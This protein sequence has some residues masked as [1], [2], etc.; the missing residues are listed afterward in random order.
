MLH[1]SR[2]A[3][4]RRSARH[5]N[6]ATGRGSFASDRRLQRRAA[7]PAAR[8]SVRRRFETGQ[9]RRGS[10]RRTLAEHAPPASARAARVRRDIVTR[11]PIVAID[12]RDAFAPQLRGW[13]RYAKELIA[14]LPEHDGLDFRFLSGGG[15]GPRLLYEQIGLPVRLRQM[16]RRP[17]PH[18]E[19]L[20]AARAAVHGR[21]DDPRPRLRGLPRGLQRPHRL[22]VPHVHAARRALGAARDLRLGLHG[23][24]RRAPLRRRRG[25]RADH[26]QRALAA[27]RRRADRRTARPLPARRRRPAPE[28]EP[29][30]PRRGVR[31]AAR[32]GA[33]APPRA[34]RRRQRRGRARPRGRR[35]PS[36]QLTG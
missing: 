9:G 11:V 22:E 8:R 4:A 16:Q 1:V 21:R 28:E 18:A 13:G 2:S 7:A 34:R 32:R 14:A 36:R 3:C 19:L 12:A 17:R 33:R 20:P 10:S 15:P 31:A 6:R 5:Q 29:P 30:A 27:D 25:A 26:P 23:E 24:R 35:R